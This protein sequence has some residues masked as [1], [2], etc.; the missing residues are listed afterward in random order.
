MGYSHTGQPQHLV[1]WGEAPGTVI[2]HGELSGGT[3]GE[4]CALHL[5]E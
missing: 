5:I 1:G 3:A 2:G 4:P